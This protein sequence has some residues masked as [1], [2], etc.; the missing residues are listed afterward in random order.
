MS[1]N[2]FNFDILE[3]DSYFMT[4]ASSNSSPSIS[5]KS[6]TKKITKKDKTVPSVRQ[7]GTS[8]LSDPQ[9]EMLKAV[10]TIFPFGKI[11]EL[12]DLIGN[13]DVQKICQYSS[14]D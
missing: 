4:K 12:R 9:R 2:D 11:Q 1:E 3:A 13:S 8:R 5:L 10:F 14:I 7:H 6:K